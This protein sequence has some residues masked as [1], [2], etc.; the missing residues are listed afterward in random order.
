M[1]T[2][3]VPLKTNSY[4]IIVGKNILPQLGTSLKS[5]SLGQDA[6]IMTHPW[7]LRR[8]GAGL[9]KTL[10]Q[11]GFSCSVFLVP[12]GEKSKSVKTAF[13]LIEKIARHDVFKRPFIVAFGGGVIG[14]LAGFV[15]ATYKRGV[16][17]VQVP[18]SFLAQID[19]AIGGKV[20]I[21][22]KF[23]KNLVGAFY[24]PRC[25]YSDVALLSTLPQRQ[26]RNG[27]AE[28]IKY[29]IIDDPKLFD[30]IES[31]CEKLLRG[32]LNSLLKVVVKSSQIKAKVVSQ[33]EK[34]TKGIRT[35][36]NFGHT[37]GHAIE[38]AGQYRVYQH[39]EAIAL[40][41][42]IASRISRDLG[43]LSQKNFER[44]D[45]LLTKAGLPKTIQKIKVNQILKMMKHDKKFIA[46]KNRFVLAKQIGKVH[47]VEGI[48]L[49]IIQRA[50]SVCA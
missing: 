27:L 28:A 11:N 2:I 46:G 22:L 19:C 37:V 43:M 4:S 49:K 44:I 38:A 35:I 21:D 20:A 34:E 36:L 48:D 45:G 33:D 31:H 29:G 16:P 32:N 41:M 10:E 26:L 23:G 12:E 30:Y 15:A 8:Y 24:Q 13:H 25:V 18:T 9:K 39:G 40:G 42:R 5:L 6:V 3:S 7:L 50:I 14:D 17:Y 47:V 1:T